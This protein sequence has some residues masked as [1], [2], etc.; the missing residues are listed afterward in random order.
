MPVPCR[1]L[2]CLATVVATSLLLP[3]T[4]A[5]ALDTVSLRLDWV[6]GSEHAPIFVAQEKGFF[7]DEGLDVKI[8]AGEGST[9][10]VKLVGNKNNDFGYATADQVLMANAKGLPIK[11]T[12]VVLQ[13]TPGCIIFPKA[14]PIR[15]LE[16]LYGKRLGTQI[17][18]VVDKQ[19]EAV[20]RMN[21]IDRSKITEIPSD[22]VVAQAM[23]AGKLDAAVA[24]FFNDGLLMEAKGVPTGWLMFSDL[25]LRVYSTSLT[26]HEDLVKQN[27]G[28][29]RRF[30]KAFMKGWT[31]SKDHPDEALALFLKAN[32]NADPVYAKLKLPAVLGLTESEDTK[33]NGLGYSTKA[34][35]ETMQRALIDMK[36][37]DAPIDV[38]NVFTNEFLK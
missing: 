17:K 11:T 5:A 26:V 33:K 35:W 36:L 20:A 1:R 27:P 8:L 14:Q 12:A 34:G 37:M 4:P 6:I 16:D 31:Y 32:P 9:V 21:R 29:V 22:R 18:S 28:L 30:T 38:G 3:F 23:I 19:W 24:F 2:W 10:V 15:K 7:K 25:G 13:N